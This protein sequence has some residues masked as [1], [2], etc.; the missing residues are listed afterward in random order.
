MSSSGGMSSDSQSRWL[1]VNQSSPVTGWKSKPTVLRMP[2][3]T[4]SRSCPS[5]VMEK[6]LVYSSDGSQMLQGAPTG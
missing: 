6:I 3:A 2:W 1:S 4:T 5:G